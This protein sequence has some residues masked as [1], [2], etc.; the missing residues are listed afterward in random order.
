MINVKILLILQIF[1]V[2]GLA[3]DNQLLERLKEVERKVKLSG[4]GSGPV[5][6]YSKGSLYVKDGVL[7]FKMPV[8]T[9]GGYHLD[10]ELYENVK[11][12][13][14]TRDNPHYVKHSELVAEVGQFDP[15]INHTHQYVDSKINEY[16][17]HVA[18]VN[19]HL[20]EH[21]TLI[22]PGGPPVHS[23]GELDEHLSLSGNPHGSTHNQLIADAGY[24]PAL[25][26]T[27]LQID[28]HMGAENPHQLHHGNV[29]DCGST[30]HALLD[31]DHNNFVSLHNPVTSEHMNQYLYARNELDL[32]RSEVN[33]HS[34]AH[35]DLVSGKGLTSHADLDIMY[36]NNAVLHDVLNSHMKQYDDAHGELV[37]HTGET[38][39]HNTT[40]LELT[41][42][43]IQHDSIDLMLQDHGSTIDDL[44]DRMI[45]VEGV[46]NAPALF[47]NTVSDIVNAWQARKNY[48]TEIDPGVFRLT[49]T[50]GG[51]W[52]IGFKV[53][54][55][56][57]DNG[58]T[59]VEAF[60]NYQ[61]DGYSDEGYV[62]QPLRHILNGGPGARNF[63]S[64]A[65]VTLEYGDVVT[66][67]FMSATYIGS[68]YF[69]SN[70]VGISTSL[71]GCT[72]S[73]SLYGV[74]VSD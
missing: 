26:N 12:R 5:D 14:V 28:A 50:K 22:W 55:Y 57:W 13:A 74:W 31:T 3:S 58:Y 34:M 73:G 36:S 69:M 54:G 30:S 64:T 41:S 7:T 2:M 60:K 38:N 63:T 19:P 35:T 17:E 33:A 15:M 16:D 39:P 4:L 59:V 45:I 40:H 29:L 10:T 37:V 11:H 21:D 51:R 48:W 9:D 68:G 8:L 52:L 62:L 65:V 44:A 56:V 66:V 71:T 61:S 6:Y 53:N 42:G 70:N 43:N 46:A 25:N 32:H 49:I 67:G 23:H 72:Y 24:D 47:A 20:I 1:S 18:S 27:H